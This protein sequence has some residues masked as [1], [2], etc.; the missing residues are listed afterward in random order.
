M[1]RF[2]QKSITD[3]FL[4][5]S[6]RPH[7]RE[8]IEKVQQCLVDG[9][10]D[11]IIEMPTGSGKSPVAIACG[12]WSE[13]SY[14]LTSQKILQ[15]QY[16]RDF[17]EDHRISVMKGRG[18]YEC[19]FLGEPTM[20]N[21][22]YE[23]AK[24]QCYK[25]GTCLYQIAK[26]RTIN[27][28][29]ALMNYSYFLNVTDCDPSKSFTERKLL[30]CDECLPGSA[31]IWIN[32]NKQVRMEELYYRQDITHVV[33]FN[34]Q[35]NSYEQKRILRRFRNEVTEKDNWFKITVECEGIIVVLKL[36]SNHNVWTKNRGMI[37]A[38]ELTTDDIVKLDMSDKTIQ[39]CCDQCEYITEN[40]HSL[41]IHRS[42]HK[43]S[44]GRCNSIKRSFARRKKQ[45]KYEQY[46]LGLSE[47]NKKQCSSVCCLSCKKEFKTSRAFN[48]HWFMHHNDGGD[49][50]WQ[51]RSEDD[52]KKMGENISK[53]LLASEKRDPE[54]YKKRWQ[55][56]SE[57]MKI[58]NP[59]FNPT[60]VEKMRQSVI[61][62]FNEKTEEE[63][64]KIRQNWINAPKKSE[65]K[66]WK[67][68]KLEQA[69]IDLQLDDI[70]YT[71]DGQFWLNIGV[72]ADG[73]PWNKNPDFKVRHQR[74]VIEVGDIKFWHTIEEV[75]QVIE[76]Y[77]LRGFECLYLTNDDFIDEN[78]SQTVLSIKKFVYNHDVKIA[79][80]KK[81]RKFNT[82][83]LKDAEKYRY[84]IE[85]E[86]NHNYFANSILVS[87]CHSLESELM[88]Q[89]E[90]LLSEFMFKRAGYPVTI[91]T[92]ESLEQYE[93][94]MKD[95]I[96]QVKTI[97]GKKNTELD[98]LNRHRVNI[99]RT[100]HEFKKLSGEATELV[101][102][103]EDIDRLY[104]RMTTF[105][106]TLGTVEWV[107][108][109]EKT[110]KLKMKRIAFRPLTVDMFAPDCLLKYGQQ[111]LYLSATILDKKSFCH[112]LGIK[113][114]EAA[115]IRVPSTFPAE[116]RKIFF[117]N[118]GYMNIANINDTLPEIVNDL[119][120]ALSY[121]KKEKGL[122][123]CH[124]YKI[125][126]YIQE[127]LQD[128][129]LIFHDTLTR[130]KMLQ[131]FML[132]DEPSVLVSPSMTEGLDLK[133]DLARW[134]VIVK[135]PYL[136]LGDKQVS[137]RM[138]IDPDWY[139]WQTCLTLVQ[140]YGRI[141]RSEEDWGTAYIFDSGA[142]GFIQRNRSI[143]PDW[144]I[145]ACQFSKGK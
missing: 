85:V 87:N 137:R 43:N 55:A 117:T 122:I 59:S 23:P 66:V 26:K 99:S 20:C 52:R 41:K 110:E 83:N 133:D 2:D 17:I 18:N 4:F 39:Y 126:N 49:K 35:T 33:S 60:T 1:V 62:T 107:F 98:T 106:N 12:L 28:Q 129:R 132:S 86:D 68:T 115:F 103:V 31:L 143:L 91:P 27:A 57:R 8:T 75:Q 78:W 145:E 84:N 130:E 51:A 93:T 89:I 142:R 88:G 125:A 61:K 100:S 46:L 30:I 118:S 128:S 131:R 120:K 113:T 94:W 34:E 38:A 58:N 124:S 7:Q 64:T 140:S 19:T 74:K 24:K 70:A 15:D 29:I 121:H 42:W 3:F 116:N 50:Q 32:D 102:Q 138:A 72:K 36:T 80:I 105:L 47:R 141:F 96:E 11:I 14:C 95:N 77:K 76:A 114:D 134:E 37:V 21:E 16:T 90:F 44:E 56:Q 71:G 53:S 6:Y 139:N 54:K 69:V 13:N 108:T 101:S 5:P 79:K 73:R 25:D 63:K 82:D 45:P 109:V 48:L 92:Y 135:I 111:R 9:V 40:V 10:K 22:C 127:N 136:Y 97:L 67:P 65:G 112:S 119:K 104:R 144:F 123:H 81:I